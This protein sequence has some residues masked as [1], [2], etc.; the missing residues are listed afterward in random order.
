MRNHSRVSVSSAGDVNGGGLDD[1]IIGAHNAGKSYVVFGKQDTAAGVL[2]A[3][4]N[5]RFTCFFLTAWIGVMCTTTYMFLLW[6]H[7]TL[8]NRMTS[9]ADEPPLLLI[10]QTLLLAKIQSALL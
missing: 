8:V 9:S 4:H 1:L 10:Y 2:F 3:K 6:V 7:K 5:I